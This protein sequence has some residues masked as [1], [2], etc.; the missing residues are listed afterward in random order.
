MI[1]SIVRATGLTIHRLRVLQ[2]GAYNVVVE[3]NDEW[4]FRFPRPGSP[5]DNVQ[6]RLQFL[7][8]FAK[9]SPLP[10]PDPVYVTDDF[11][12][13]RKISGSHLYPTQVARLPNAAKQR[14]AEQLAEFLSALHHHEDPGGRGCE[15]RNSLGDRTR[16]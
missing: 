11:V 15:R 4:I 6:E 1:A 10:V 8:S 14:V 5:R 16:K 13:Y 3:V 9:V 7:E 2:H 12:A